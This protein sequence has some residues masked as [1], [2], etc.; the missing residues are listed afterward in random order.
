LARRKSANHIN[1]GLQIP[2]IFPAD[3][4]NSFTIIEISMFE[5]GSIGV[6]K[7]LIK[8]LF[9]HIEQGV[10]IVPQDVEFTT[11]KTPK[12]NRGIRGNVVMI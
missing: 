8:L 9:E 6:K 2:F 12:Y 4:S 7:S 11:L 10:G 5:G 1:H 3:R